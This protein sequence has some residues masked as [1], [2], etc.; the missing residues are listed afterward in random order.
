MALKDCIKKLGK[1]V[2][3]ADKK[4]L[5]GWIDQGL[6]DDVVLQRYD[7]HI[8]KKLVDIS[9]RAQKKGAKVSV[10]PRESPPG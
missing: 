4:L 6:D 7:L 3:A 5:Q 1:A 8:Q 9:A 10:R 2:T